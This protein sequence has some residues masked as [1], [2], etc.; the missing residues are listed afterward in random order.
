[1]TPTFAP[2]PVRRP[3]ARRS[4]T[5]RRL[6]GSRSERNRVQRCANLRDA[7]RARQ[8]IE[9]AAGTSAS[10]RP[11][12][13]DSTVPPAATIA[14]WAPAPIR[15]DDDSHLL[16]AVSSPLRLAVASACVGVAAPA[17]L[18]S[19]ESSRGSSR[20]RSAA[21]TGLRATGLC[22]GRGADEGDGE[23]DQQRQDHEPRGRT[24]RSRCLIS[25]PL[26]RRCR[27]CR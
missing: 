5:S 9:P 26:H 6:P 3:R 4:R 23:R 21:P 11:P 12:A 17:T 15:L 22:G 16:F 8:R 10:T 25:V 20:P 19:R 2:V 7:A 27:G 13:A 1:M 18:S 14:A 24:P